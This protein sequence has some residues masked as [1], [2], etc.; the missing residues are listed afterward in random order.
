MSQLVIVGN[1]RHFS[2]RK[3]GQ[4]I[5]KYFTKATVYSLHRHLM[6]S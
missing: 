1:C 4:L 2:E 6:D 3:E 5:G